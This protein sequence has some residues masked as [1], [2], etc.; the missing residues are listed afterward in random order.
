MLS[1]SEGR[2]V[3]K[4]VAIHF[5]KTEAQLSP[6][7]FIQRNQQQSHLLRIF[8]SDYSPTHMPTKL[9]QSPCSLRV[10]SLIINLSFFSL[11]FFNL[12]SRTVSV[13]G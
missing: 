5:G 7:T 9:S 3:Q 2:R 1:Q 13:L 4:R 8:F 12:I 11:F 6:T 10:N